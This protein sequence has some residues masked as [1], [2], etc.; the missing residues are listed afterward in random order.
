MIVPW[1]CP[2]SA[3]RASFLLCFRRHPGFSPQQAG[4]WNLC[5]VN[6]EAVQ[7]M[8]CSCP[9]VGTERVSSEA[10]RVGWCVSTDQAA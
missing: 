7:S 8:A 6:R 1:G 4:H 3:V 2:R 9:C 10:A 5:M